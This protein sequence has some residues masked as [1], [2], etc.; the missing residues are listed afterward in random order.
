M[1][2]VVPPMASPSS[3]FPDKSISQRLC[4]NKYASTGTIITI[5]SIITMPIKTNPISIACVI[6]KDN[7]LSV[8]K[9]LFKQFTH[10]FTNFVKIAVITYRTFFGIFFIT[11][12]IWIDEQII[13]IQ[14]IGIKNRRNFIHLWKIRCHA[15]FCHKNNHPLIVF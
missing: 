4:A 2:A 10:Y 15:A 5:I 11:S 7:E 6:Y 1:G 9:L 8:Q 14:K 12:L 3:F 13:S